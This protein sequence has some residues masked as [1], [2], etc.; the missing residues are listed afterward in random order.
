MHDP[1]KMAADASITTRGQTISLLMRSVSLVGLLALLVAATALDLATLPVAHAGA[2]MGEQGQ[3]WASVAKLPDWRGIW[4]LDWEHNPR[5]LGGGSPGPLTPAAQA[6]LDTFLQGQKKG[7]NLQTQDANCLPTGM[8]GIMTEPY[9][10]EFLFNPGMVVM[11]IE[12]FSQ[13]RH[14]YTNGETHP[15]D[16]DPAFNGHSIGHWEGDTLVVDTVG[17]DTTTHIAPGV[18]HSDALHIVERI[19]R[20]DENHIQIERTISDPQILAKPWT[21]VLPYARLKGHL[22]EYVCE[23]NNRDSADAQGRPDLR[24]DAQKN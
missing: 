5:L 19:R 16:P 14:V 24:I 6:K 11:V 10:I 4:Q 13:V 12:T 23:Q 3:T 17:I 1:T 8:P 2:P 9:P 15:A 18:A 20:V 7:E 22:R 21:Q